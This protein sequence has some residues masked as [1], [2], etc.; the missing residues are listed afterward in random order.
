MSNVEEIGLCLQ[1]HD[2]ETFIDGKHLKRNII[3]R[4]RRLNHFTFS[5][6]S[7]MS[8]R[9]KLYLP[10]TK[11]IQCTFIDF[12]MNNIISYVDYFSEVHKGGRC[13]IYSYPH[14]MEYYGDITNNFPGGL[15]EYVRVVSLYDEYPFEHEFFVR[16]QKSFPFVE[17]LSLNNRKPQ[18]AKQSYEANNDHRNVS[19][20]QYSFLYQLS[21]VNV[22]DDYI[23]EFL[24]D[25]KT[26]LPNNVILFIKYES[27]ERVTHNFTRDVTRINCTKIDK[28][29]L[30]GA[31]KCSNSLE[32][33]FP[34]AKI[35]YP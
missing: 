26:Y 29:N 32:E 17:K 5:I 27:L 11:D 31:T 1:V 25:T 7:F 24:F 20:I 2:K 8:T 34:Y 35:F 19:V 10:S 16:I 22:H 18:N 4:M 23:E 21:I 12:P 33:Y 13:H 6:T 15:F 14:Q 28:L 9:D 30:C 3:N